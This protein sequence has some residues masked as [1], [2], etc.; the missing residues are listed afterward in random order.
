MNALVAIDH[1]SKDSVLNEVARVV[2]DV[3]GE[4]WAS[5]I[6]ISLTSSFADDLELESIEFVALAERLKEKYGKKVDFAGWLAKKELK[7][8]IGLRVGDLVE[9]IAA[10]LSKSETA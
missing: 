7:E 6:P 3:I 10:C 9:F 1:V 5:D 8:I 2:R 4:E